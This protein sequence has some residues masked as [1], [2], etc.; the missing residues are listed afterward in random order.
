MTAISSLPNLG[1]LYTEREV[2][3]L[4][5]GLL[6]ANT[7]RS[8]R[9]LGKGPAFIKVGNRVQYREADVIEFLEAGYQQAS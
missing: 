1:P 9:S 8:W 3:E 7:L 2:E 4:T 6:R 5:N